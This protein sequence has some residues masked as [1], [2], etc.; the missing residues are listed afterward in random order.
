MTTTL[1]R[2]GRES[3]RTLAAVRERGVVRVAVSRGILGLSCP[4]PDGQWAGLDVEFARAVAAAAG[5]T[6]EFRP[7]DPADRLAVLAGGEV[8]LVTANL[9]ASLPR[10]AGHGVTFAAVTCYDGEG[11]LVRA[12]E[13]VRTPQDLAGRPVAVQAGT[14]S[15]ANLRRY[16]GAGAVP[17]AYATPAEA[18]AAYEAGV[19]AAYLLDRTA[20]AGERAQLTDPVA[21]RLLDET[22]SREPMA[23]AA[24]DD[25]P[26]WLRLCRWVPQLAVNLEYA[27]RAG[28]PAARATLA[29][30]ADPLGAALGVG[31]GWATRVLDAVGDYG[32]IYDRTLG[33]AS[34]LS[35]PRGLNELWT[36]GGLH[37]P[38]PLT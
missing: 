36:A 27:R 33:D 17:V 5:V 19:C 4:G 25:D 32:D 3:T 15:A 35:L 24:R 23:L 37:Y 9:T 10:E 12:D 34:P 29:A 16:L 38:L 6:A 13:P 26:A 11:F 30:E 8:D 2:T 21:H 14:T 7:V 22:I 20:L 28:G 31:E 1:T 18:R